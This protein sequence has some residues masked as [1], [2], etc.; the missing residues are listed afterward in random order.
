MSGAVLEDLP[1]SV[2]IAGRKYTAA[3]DHGVAVLLTAAGW[4]LQRLPGQVIEEHRSELIR[5]LGQARNLIVEV[6]C[7]PTAMV[8]VKDGK[9]LLVEIPAEGRQQGRTRAS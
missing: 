9:R 8:R 2:T 3:A 5:T 6:T 1:Q 7:T 4:I